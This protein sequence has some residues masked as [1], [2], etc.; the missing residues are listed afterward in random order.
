[1]KKHLAIAASVIALAA[2]PALADNHEAA[3]HEFPLSMADFMAAYPDVTPEQFA[4]IDED[5][6]AQVSEDE[7]EAAKEAGT[8]G[9][10]D[11]A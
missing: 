6:D 1:M 11:E 9:D 5:G 2:A 10:D 7:Y 8:I 3:E 4:E